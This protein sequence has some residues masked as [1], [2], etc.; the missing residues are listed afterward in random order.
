MNSTLCS[1]KERF[2]LTEQLFDTLKELEDKLEEEQEQETVLEADTQSDSYDERGIWRQLVSP[3]LTVHVQPVSKQ[4]F[5][6]NSAFNYRL[7]TTLLSW[8]GRD[9]LWFFRFKDSER[10][11]NKSKARATLDKNKQRTKGRLLS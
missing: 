3:K 4:P 8:P 6:A 9:R 5:S 1:L 10:E 7:N 11:I 2:Q